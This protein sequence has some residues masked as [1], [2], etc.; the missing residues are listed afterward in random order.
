MA[1]Q[2]YETQLLL[3]QTCQASPDIEL[4]ALIEGDGRIHAFSPKDTSM[5]EIIAPLVVGLADVADRSAQELGRGMLETFLV[6]AS[7]G[8]VL[9]RDLGN[10]S[11]LAALARDRSSIGIVM[12]DMRQCA[13]RIVGE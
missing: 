7:Q 5:S 11:I 10:G 6:E 1:L 2:R 4:L 9:G 3:D 13:K 8:I 12:H